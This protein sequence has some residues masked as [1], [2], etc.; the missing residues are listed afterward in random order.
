MTLFLWTIDDIGNSITKSEKRCKRT[1]VYAAL[2]PDVGDLCAQG[3]RLA[4]E[5]VASNGYSTMTALLALCVGVRAWDGCE[6]AAWRSPAAVPVRLIDNQMPRD[7]LMLFLF[8][9]A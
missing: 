3:V 8:P 4:G 9:A 1:G 2:P 5:F 6:C 7:T